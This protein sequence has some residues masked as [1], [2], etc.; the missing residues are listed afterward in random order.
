MLEIQKYHKI[1]V[2]NWKL[3]AST[4][5]IKSYL[6][7]IRF[8]LTPRYTCLIVICP[9]F[10]FIN[11]LSS[12]GFAIGGQDCSI[13]SQGAYT[14]ETSTKMLK[15]V[16]CEFCVIGHSERRNLFGETDDII[17]QKALRCFDEDIIP[18]LC[19]GENL[20]QRE[21]KVTKNVLRKQIDKCVPNEANKH[22]M[23]IAYEPIWAIGTGKTPT[24]DEIIDIHSF[25]SKLDKTNNFKILYGGS[26]NASNSKQILSLERVDG[27]LSGGSSIDINEFNKIINL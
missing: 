3:N 1:I 5:F 7:N 11:K 22:N 21:N 6:S 8:E 23:I 10:P 18:I 9:P 14:G 12:K 13:Y 24:F 17:S 15:D 19:I 4:Q 27:I 26:V 16:G 25:I 2:A 20:K